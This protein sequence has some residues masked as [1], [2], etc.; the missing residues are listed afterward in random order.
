MQAVPAALGT[1]LLHWPVVETQLLASRQSVADGQVMPAH[2]DGWMQEPLPS[3]RS[4]VVPS[5]SSVHE[6]PADTGS[7]RHV[8]LGPKHEGAIKQS[9]ASLWQVTVAHAFADHADGGP[10]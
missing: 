1:L 6:V 8:P 2:L 7:P 3:H 4:N 10:S 9:V 5:A